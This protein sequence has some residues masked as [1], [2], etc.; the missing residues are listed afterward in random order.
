MIS[1][2]SCTLLPRK[3]G[4]LFGGP[5]DS[6]DSLPAR[7]RSL[8]GVEDVAEAVTNVI[9]EFLGHPLIALEGLGGGAVMIES[10][11]GFRVVLDGVPWTVLAPQRKTTAHLTSTYALRG[12]VTIASA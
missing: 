5:F 2:S 9:A 6:N 11:V 4:W 8:V 10:S 3:L 12:T 7:L 1:F